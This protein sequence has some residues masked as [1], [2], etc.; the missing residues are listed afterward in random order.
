[1]QGP[2]PSTGSGAEPSLPQVALMLYHGT[3]VLRLLMTCTHLQ[4]ARCVKDGRLRPL[5]AQQ[6]VAMQAASCLAPTT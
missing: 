3:D 4:A 6:R 2:S 1:M 5:I